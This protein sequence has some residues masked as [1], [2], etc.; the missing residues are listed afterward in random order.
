[1]PDLSR[2]ESC[3]HI[4]TAQLRSGIRGFVIFSS[5]VSK[6]QM[7]ESAEFEYRPW[8]LGESMESRSSAGGCEVIAIAFLVVSLPVLVEG[9]W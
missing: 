7:H 4:Q 8:F 9:A 5:R 2:G 6:M 3:D 1:M